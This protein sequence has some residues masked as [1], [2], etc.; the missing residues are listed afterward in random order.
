MPTR[1]PISTIS[2]NTQPFLAYTFSELAA[3]GKIVLAH[4]IEH[5]PDDEVPDKKHSHVYLEPEGPVDKIDLRELFVEENPDCLYMPFGCEP[6]RKSKFE[7][8]YLYCCHNPGYLKKRGYTTER[9]QYF[10]ADFQSTSLATFRWQVNSEINYARHGI[11]NES[12][13]S[14]KDVIAN[15]AKQGLSYSTAILNPQVMINNNVHNYERVYFAQR[16][17]RLAELQL[18][19]QGITLDDPD[20]PK[21]KESLIMEMEGTEQRIAD[22]LDIALEKIQREAIDVICE[23]KWKEANPGIVF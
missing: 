9:R 18:L 7:D 8:W 23:N 3:V 19:K 14:P 1:S 6:W 13:D 20:F 2:Y 17:S 4:W 12:G 5:E 15:A 22:A 10:L 21:M 11:T 16:F